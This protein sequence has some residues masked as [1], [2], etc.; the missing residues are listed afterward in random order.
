MGS[1]KITGTLGRAYRV[2]ERICGSKPGYPWT[3]G[4]VSANGAPS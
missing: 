4:Q 2:A 1:A 3:L